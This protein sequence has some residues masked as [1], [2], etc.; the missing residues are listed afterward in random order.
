MSP[1]PTRSAR[2]PDRHVQPPSSSTAVP[3][4]PAARPVRSRNRQHPGHAL[5][6]HVSRA[7]WP[8]SRPGPRRPLPAGTTPRPTARTAGAGPPKLRSGPCNDW[9]TRFAGARPGACARASTTRTS[10]SGGGGRR[11]APITL[12]SAAGGAAEVVGRM[13][14]AQVPPTTCTSPGCGSMAVTPTCCPARRSTRSATRSSDDDVTNDHTGICFELGSS[15]G[16]GRA[17]ATLLAHNRIHDCGI[18]PAT[19][20]ESRH[21]RR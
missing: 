16:W 18:L 19:N 10:S 21:L 6:L 5:G 20:D 13:W 3:R 12:T 7:R 11:H 8:L 15:Q 1:L 4:F 2:R 14:I 9:S 17:V